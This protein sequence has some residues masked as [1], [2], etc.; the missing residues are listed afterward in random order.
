MITSRTLKG[1][2]FNTEDGH[3]VFV[4]ICIEKN[5]KKVKIS[6]ELKKG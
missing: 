6:F 3:M 1:G 5:D 2:W 4:N